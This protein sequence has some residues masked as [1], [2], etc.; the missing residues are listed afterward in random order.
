MT[1]QLGEKLR[2]G[3]ALYQG[4][5]LAVPQAQCAQCRALA[6]APCFLE[7]SLNARLFHQAVQSCR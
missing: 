7:F 3:R 1:S 5:A 2:F 4:M 6:P